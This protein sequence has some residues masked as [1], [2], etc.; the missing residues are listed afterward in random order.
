M[1][2]ET[3]RLSIRPTISDD[4]ERLADLWCDAD[5]T[6][7]SGGPR[8][9]QKVLAAIK[10]A[11][12]G[13]AKGNRW[14]VI[15]KENDRLIGECGLLEKQVDGKH[16][17]E[18]IY[19]FEKRAW[20]QGYATEASQAILSYAFDTLKLARVIALIHPD[21]LPSESVAVRLGLSFERN[22]DRDGHLKKM[23]VIAQK[24]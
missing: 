3:K 12:E 20:G 15:Q 5:V 17:T 19:Y 2:F 23:F 18:I 6:Q 7:F 16:E 8:E 14:S 11:T 21:N 24:D 10:S 9:R 4:A 22:V 1:K 13:P